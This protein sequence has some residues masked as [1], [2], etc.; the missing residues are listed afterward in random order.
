MPGL[1][2]SEFLEVVPGA[3]AVEKRGIKAVLQ[4]LKRGDEKGAAKAYV[5]MM[6]AVGDKVVDLFHD[7]GLFADAAMR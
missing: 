1:Q 7:R 5:A 2:P 6:S 3:V 4:A